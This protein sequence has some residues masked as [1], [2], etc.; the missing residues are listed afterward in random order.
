MK[1]KVS[2]VVPVYG[3]EDYLDRCVQSLCN[4]TLKDIEIILV[5]DGSP[6]NCPSMCDEYARQDFRISVVHKRNAGLGMAC[7]S[8]LEVAKGEYIAFCD[9]DDWLDV[10]MYQMLYNAAIEHNAQVVY[11]GLKRVDVKGKVLS[12]MTHPQFEEIYKKEDVLNLACDMIASPPESKADR[13]IQVSAKTV[14]YELAFLKKNN[15]RFVSEREY[16]SEDLLFNVSVLTKANSVTILPVHFYN[17]MVNANS[18]TGRLKPNHFVNVLKSAEYLRQLFEGHDI[19]DDALTRVERFVMGES[20]SYL[21]QIIRSYLSE[22]EKRDKVR[23]LSLNTSL[24]EIASHYPIKK[25][26][27]I[28]L[29]VLR[30]LMSNQYHL[31]KLLYSIK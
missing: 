15:L 7:N 9:S 13:R 26:P 1:P 2:I 29:L 3:V 6:D 18:I 4:Q 27:F 14:L 30:L 23:E 28:H 11:T 22:K 10:E 5:D 8:G 25:M 12:L 31:L 19:F 17:Y 24:R 16:P 21:R 20:R